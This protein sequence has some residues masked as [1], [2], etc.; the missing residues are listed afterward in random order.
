MNK[1]YVSMT[2]EDHNNATM[3]QNCRMEPFFEA[4]M[5]MKQSE[6]HSSNSIEENK[7]AMKMGQFREVNS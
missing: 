7:F 3:H 2:D 5:L 1:S 4:G 6:E